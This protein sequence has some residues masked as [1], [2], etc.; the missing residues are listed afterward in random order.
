[1]NRKN[2]HTTTIVPTGCA[3]ADRHL[4][5]AIVNAKGGSGKTTLAC[6]LAAELTKRGKRVTLI[7]ADPL[8][9]TRAWHEVG[10]PLQ[11]LRLITEATQ[12]VTVAAAEATRTSTVLIDAAGFAT[13]TTVAALEAADLVLVPCKASALDAVRAIETVA[14]AREVSK[15]RR[16]R[17][18][19]KVLLNGVTHS[20]VTPHIRS[21]L[22]KAGVDV[23]EAEIGQR[24]A[25]VVAAINGTAPCWMGYTARQAAEDVAAVA[26]E[27]KL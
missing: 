20:S 5:I 11:T 19:I 7:D 23:L 22:E 14:L 26:D 17:V 9:G 24:S 4:A 13:S 2:P 15:A 16:R 1:M 21:E 12:G 6:S 25:F 18:P 10:G 27:L 8:G 3:V